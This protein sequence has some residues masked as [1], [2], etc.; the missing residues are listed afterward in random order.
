MPACALDGFDMLAQSGS[1]IRNA[2]SIVSP[3]EKHPS[4][5]GNQTPNAL[6]SSFSMTAIAPRVN[7]TPPPGAPRSLSPLWTS[8]RVGWCEQ[9][10]LS[11]GAP[12]S[13]SRGRRKAHDPLRGACRHHQF[14]LP[15]RGLPPA[16]DGGGRPARSALPPSASP[17]ATASPASCAPSA[18]G[19]ADKAVKLLVGTRLVT[20]DGFEVIAYPTDRAAYGRLCRLLTKGNV[21]VKK[22]QKGEYHLAFADVAGRQRQARC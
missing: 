8:L 15:A 17:T 9:V 7:P 12:P 22:G 14:L 13:R 21:K 5:S 19:S 10:G 11:D 20:T 4:T 18:S 16:G 2:S 1:G 6:S 3:A